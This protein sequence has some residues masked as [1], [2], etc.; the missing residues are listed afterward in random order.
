MR[1][2]VLFLVHGTASS[3]EA[4]RA[5]GLARCLE[6]FEV[7]LAYRESTKLSTALQWNGA[8][9]EYRPEIVY[10]VNT[11]LP[12]A[13]LA[14]LWSVGKSQ[15]YILDTGDLVH[16]MARRSGIGGGWKL[17]WLRYWENLAQRRATAIVVRGTYHRDYLLAQKFPRVDV[18]RD[19][20]SENQE[21]D[22]ATLSSLRSQLGLEG[23]FVMGVMGSLT[24]SSRLEICYGWDLIQA[25]ARISDP[26]V[27]GL[28]I[29]DGDG[30]PRLEAMAAQLGVRER[31][32]FCGRIPYA[33]VPAHLRLMD[34]ALST[35]TNNLPGKV[36]TTGKLPEYMAAGRFVLASRVGEASLI[37][38]EL[39][40]VEFEGEVDRNY[41]LRLAERVKLL[42]QEPELLEARRAMPSLAERLFS[43][44]RLSNQLSE[45]LHSTCRSGADFTTRGPGTQ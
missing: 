15:R 44:P 13:V 41:P 32:T 23:R 26:T 35:Q 37:L 6:A 9:R 21:V 24:W 33:S 5:K 19:G 43:Y 4:V 25:L 12:G 36:R 39:M 42:R 31:V 40:L 29:G 22:S 10:V 3:I 28:I 18:I 2:R 8:V 38:P 45:L 27:V 17:P 14:P 7:R 34:V 11:A 20:Y 16:E 30:R 1:P